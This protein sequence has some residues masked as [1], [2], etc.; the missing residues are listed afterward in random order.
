[1]FNI[2]CKTT[3]IKNENYDIDSHEELVSLRK[4]IN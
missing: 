3:S 2:Q 1:M 4:I